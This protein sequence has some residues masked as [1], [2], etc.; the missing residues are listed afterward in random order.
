MLLFG[1]MVTKAPIG[2]QPDLNTANRPVAILVAVAA[3]GL[4]VTTL[5]DAF[6]FA[7]LDLSDSA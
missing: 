5:V 1:L 2:V 6:R 3:F 4:L 7:H